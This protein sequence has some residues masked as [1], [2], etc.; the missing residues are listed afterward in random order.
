M[1]RGMRV[2]MMPGSASFR[3]LETMTSGPSRG[4]FSRPWTLILA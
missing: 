2:Q 4:T 1:R 3:W